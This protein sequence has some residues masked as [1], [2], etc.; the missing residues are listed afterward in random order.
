MP[1]NGKGLFSKMGSHEAWYLYSLLYMYINFNHSK[2]L[3]LV[4]VHRLCS[5]E[6]SNSREECLNFSVIL[7]IYKHTYAYVVI[8]GTHIY[9]SFSGIT[10]MMMMNCVIRAK[11]WLLGILHCSNTWV[12]YVCILEFLTLINV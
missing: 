7:Y 3:C 11:I 1:Y 8:I 2:L 9:F 6:T 4:Y 5:A 12:I 10:L